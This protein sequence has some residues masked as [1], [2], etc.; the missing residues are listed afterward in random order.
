[1]GQQQERDRNKKRKQLNTVYV[2]TGQ[3]IPAT[4]LNKRTSNSYPIQP[5][6]ALSYD[7]TGCY[8]H[9]AVCRD[10]NKIRFV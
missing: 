1:M 9:G 7:A 6:E 10:G 2:E 3:Y 4:S 5:H 8:H